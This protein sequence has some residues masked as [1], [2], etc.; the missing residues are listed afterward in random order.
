MDQRVLE[1]LNEHIGELVKK[2]PPLK[3][4][5]VYG[6]A[7]RKELTKGSDVDILVIVDDTS[8]KFTPNLLD[9]LSEEM[10]ALSR[11]GQ[12]VIG[13]D[14]HFQSPKPLSIWWDLLRSGEPWVTTAISDAYVVYDP[15]DYVTPLKTLIN[16]G[17]IHGTREKAQ[18]LIER[19][20]YRL[21]EARRVLLEDITAEML[22]AMAETAQAVLM[23]YGVPPPAAKNLGFELRKYFIDTK[24]LDPRAV[25]YYEDFFEFTEKISHGEITR[26]TG[27]D[28]KKHLQRAVYFIERVDQLFVIIEA[29]KK[30]E[31]INKSYDRVA[32]ACTETLHVK[33][34]DKKAIEKFKQEFID[35]GMVSHSY[36]AIIEKI[37]N[38]K[39][40]SE[41][42]K[43]KE[44]PERDIY[45]SVVYAKNL[46]EI[47][48]KT[49][50]RD[51]VTLEQEIK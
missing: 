19:A 14:L 24:M 9:Y 49:Q 17:R 31:I 4:V 51:E 45:S 34:F 38:L 2:Y 37:F 39:N 15:S 36:L 42:G 32:R 18:A 44:I 10:S 12:E 11:K 30:T 8:E 35:T 23:F 48:K 7:T 20:P 25:E 5:F 1:F 26:V 22:C 13:V 47:I 6:S 3:A 50:S 16:Q 46:E 33:A 41:K 27:K 43:L 28:I 29:N 40:L 21:K